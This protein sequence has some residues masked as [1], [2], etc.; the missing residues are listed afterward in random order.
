MKFEIPDS[1]VYMGTGILVDRVVQNIFGSGI[2][3]VIINV[4]YEIDKAQKLREIETRRVVDVMG[5]TLG[6][7]DSDGNIVKGDIDDY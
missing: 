1:V 2:R 4:L 3:D 7:V 6:Y 5:D